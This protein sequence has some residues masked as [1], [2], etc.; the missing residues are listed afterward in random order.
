MIQR[1]MERV[2]RFVL[3]SLFLLLLSC[4]KSA[5]QTGGTLA[6]DSAQKAQT[7]LESTIA[8]F[9]GSSPQGSS[10]TFVGT[11]YG[12]V[13]VVVGESYHS[14]LNMECREAQVRGSSRTR[15]AAC[16]DPKAGWVLAPDIVGDGAF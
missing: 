5:T 6:E 13:T 4:A 11:N 14:A 10:E 16:K 7:P 15:I 1:N 12:T 8:N 3:F 9:I 2:R